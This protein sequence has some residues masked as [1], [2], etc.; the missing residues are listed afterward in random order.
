[1]TTAGQTLPLT[2]II[3]PEDQA[4]LAQVVRR[5]YD[6]GTPIYPI[7]GGTS[8]ACG[9][10][11]KRPGWGVSLAKLCHVVDYPSRDM[12]ITVEAGITMAALAALLAGER[13]RLPIDAPQAAVATLGGVVATNFSG[14][15]RYGLGTVRDYVIG[16]R[17]V[18]G[19]GTPFKGGGRVVKNVAG[20]DFCKLL[21]GSLGTLGIITELALKVKPQAEASAFLACD[22]SDLGQAETLLAALVHSRATPTAIELLAGPAWQD[23]GELAALAPGAAARLV[24]GL[25]GTAVEVGWMLDELSREWQSQGVAAF[26]TT[27]SERADH[28]WNRLTDFAVDDDSPLVVKFNVRPSAVTSVLALLLE[29]DPHSSIQAHAGNGIVVARFSRFSAADTSRVLIGRLQPAAAAAG[30]N[31]VIWCCPQAGELTRQAVWGATRGETALMRAVKQQFDPR[32]LL[33]PG[34]YVYG[35]A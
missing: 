35:T 25:E 31:V 23:G 20:Y 3:S 17:A 32:G 12:T 10:P 18:D 21:T 4:E 19:R 24:V 15:R 7:G 6:A 22:L 28:V 14:P 2:E 33:N 1:M 27:P 34:R 5:A 13:Q 26:Q 30:G 8:L 9:L 16:I 11:A 29:I